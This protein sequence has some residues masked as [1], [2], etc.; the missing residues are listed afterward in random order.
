MTKLEAALWEADAALKKLQPEQ[1]RVARRNARQAMLKAL[2]KAREALDEQYPVKRK[3]IRRRRKTRTPHEL[4]KDKL[5]VTATEAARLLKAGVTTG[6]VIDLPG[7]RGAT[8]WYATW[9]I[10]R[11]HRAGMPL[12][13]IVAAMRSQATRKGIQATLKLKG[14]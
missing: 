2:R 12:K 7:V 10:A 1:G 5:V 11:A 14:V 13:T 8:A 3:P 6:H 4:K 9:W